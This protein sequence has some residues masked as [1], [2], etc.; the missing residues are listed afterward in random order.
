M[1]ALATLIVGAGYAAL[2][3]AAKAAPRSSGGR[4]PVVWAVLTIAA[5]IGAEK[6]WDAMPFGDNHLLAM[7]A[8]GFAIA[9]CLAFAAITAAGLA[10]SLVIVFVATALA[11][12][13]AE[14]W[15]D[16]WPQ[17]TVLVLPLTAFSAGDSAAQARQ[18]G[19]GPADAARAAR[20]R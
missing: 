17:T 9:G 15:P 8:F 7:R 19:G 14:A 3:Y 2:S 5:F 10:R 4:W 18:P 12:L 1:A 20:D 6:L 13:V 16:A 11:L